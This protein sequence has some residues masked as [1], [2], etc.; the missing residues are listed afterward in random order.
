MFAWRGVFHFVVAR[1]DVEYVPAATAQRTTDSVATERPDAPWG[2]WHP[3]WPAA[4]TPPW[5]KKKLAPRPIMHAVVVQIEN[6]RGVT[7]GA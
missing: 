5:A 3:T 7:V 1:G 4:D 2:A 6:H